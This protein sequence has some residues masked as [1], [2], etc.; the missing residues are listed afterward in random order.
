[1][2]LGI[3][4]ACCKVLRKN[5]LKANVDHQCLRRKRHQSVFT[6]NTVQLAPPTQFK[7][8]IN[9]ADDNHKDSRLG[10]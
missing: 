1:M 6:A 3:I 7:S 5:E 9:I 10:A 4:S 2:E 8:F